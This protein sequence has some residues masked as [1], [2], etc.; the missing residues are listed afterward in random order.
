M[1]LSKE[2][3]EFQEE[4]IR[5]MS[6][7]EESIESEMDTLSDDEDDG[8]LTDAPTTKEP[9]STD[10]PKVEDGAQTDPPKTEPPATEPPDEIA[11]LK[12]DIAELKRMLAEKDAP[13]T[14]APTTEEP[15]EEEDFLG[16]MDV[17]DVTGDRA[18]LNKLLNKV[19]MKGVQTGQERSKKL[20]NVT[21]ESISASIRGNIMDVAA[22]TKASEEF[23]DENEDLLPHKAKVQSVYEDLA[24]ANPDKDHLEIL[25]L[26]GPEVR[27]RYDIKPVKKDTLVD[28]DP[29]PKLPG[30]KSQRRATSKDKD[31]SNPMLDEMD[32][33]EKALNS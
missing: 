17:V 14:E 27:K 23:Y 31:K 1:E 11:S 26:T 5:Q 33:M 8:D 21:D 3:K 10:P 20:V 22:I 24:S 2:E 19:Y 13:K 15:I 4:Q 9:P 16:D 12:D 28:D 7:M 29:P 18:E 25:E 30:K 6:D 32:E